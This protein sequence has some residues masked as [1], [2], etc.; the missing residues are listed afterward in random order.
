MKI[1]IYTN[2]EKDKGLVRTKQAAA[3]LDERG[4]PYAVHSGISGLMQAEVFGED[5]CGITHL[6]VFGGDGTLLKIASQAARAGI[7]L[8]GVNTGSLGF[9]SEIDGPGLEEGIA[10][11]AEGR[12]RLEERAMLESS[13]DGRIYTALNEFTFMREN[14][15]GSLSRVVRLEAYAGDKLIDRFVADGLIVSTPTGSTAYSLSCGGPVLAPDVR[16][17]I[18]Q[19]VA[20]HSLHSRSV[21]VSIDESIT[22]RTLTNSRVIIS[23]DGE[24][25]AEYTGKQSITIR[26]SDISAK[27]IRIREDG[28]YG[29]LLTKLNKWSTAL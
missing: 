6:M 8:L 15:V 24:A 14:A 10:C 7:P 21:V 9:L 13:I 29:K 3:L 18:V 25:A 4:I 1:G 27:F 5:F 11:L 23:A 26:R 12:Y 20:A 28:F 19:P 17:V 22:V 16:A 2:T